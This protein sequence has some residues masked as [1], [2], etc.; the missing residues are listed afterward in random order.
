MKIK[1][2]LVTPGME[3]QKVRIPASTKFMK[4]FMGNNLIKLSVS[5]NIAFFASS[6]PNIDDF[7]RIY[8]GR[9]LMGPFFVVGLKN[10]KLVSLKKR[11]LKKYFNMF[12]LSKH[13]KVSEIKNE[14][15]EKYYL[16]Q[17]KLKKA[18]EKENKQK[19]FGIA[20]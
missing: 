10:Q 4:S 14:Y 16:N 18:A 7:N 6:N 9:V 20:A 1:V 8:R 17:R 2:L 12:K 5:E 15:L 19:I 3:V 11:E 13:K